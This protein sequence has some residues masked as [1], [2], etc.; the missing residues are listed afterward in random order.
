[1]RTPLRSF[2]L[3]LLTAL[4]TLSL[5]LSSCAGGAAPEMPVIEEPAAEEAVAPEPTTVE[6]IIPE[7]TKVMDGETLGSLESLSPDKSTFTFSQVTPALEALADGDVIAGGVTPHTPD[8]FLRKVT[9]VSV[10]GDRVVVQT[11][12]AT[13]EEA[14]ERGRI[15]GGQTLTPQDV[16]AASQ[17]A[18][19]RLKSMPRGTDVGVFEIEVNH[20]LSDEDGDPQT[21]SD[22]VR[23]VG[24]ISF[25]PSYTFELDIDHATIRRLTFVYTTTETVELEIQS[26]VEIVEVH[27]RQKLASYEFLPLEIPVGILPVLI[28]PVLT[29]EAG[30]DGSVS[31]GMSTS[32]S[33]S[34][35]RAADLRYD[36]GN[37]SLEPCV[38]RDFEYTPPSVSVTSRAQVYAGPKLELLIYGVVGPTCA[39]HGYLAFDAD[40]GRTPWWELYAGLRGEV[41][42]EVEV[43][44]RVIARYSATLFDEKW[45]LAQAETPPELPPPASG[46]G[47]IAFVSNRD[48]GLEIYVM[49]ADGSGLMRVTDD[50]ISKEDPDWSP[51]GTRIAFTGKHEGNLDVYVVS[52]DGSGL[53]RLTHDEAVD[54]DPD[55]SPDGARIAFES[56]RD[57]DWEI[58]VMNAD[59]SGVTRLTDN[60]VDDTRPAW[61]PDGG[62]IAFTREGEIMIMDADGSNAMQLTDNPGFDCCPA[63]SPD[64][65][66]LSFRSRLNGSWHEDEIFV[67]DTDGSGL[68]RLTDNTDSDDVSAWSAD[69]TRIVFD[70]NRDGNC[71]IYVM[72]A[73]GSDQRN[74]SN[75]PSVDIDPDWGR[76][77]SGE[78]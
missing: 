69:G 61:S 19:V 51:D 64:G 28:T 14:I 43:L 70:T 27:E 17:G 35:T 16:R 12:Q 68:T 56:S 11:V 48:G 58:Y 18:G 57:G 23:A 67:M 77:P 42:V 6:P 32:A 73:D 66:R 26:Q 9:A 76:C 44:S 8:G 7:T 52:A 4:L 5:S 46:G 30:V 60:A 39:V 10:D 71:E 22:Q 38:K 55:W 24:T 47:R 13:L 74:L 21:T 1:M 31:V 34:M 78:T 53:V 54:R 29:V 63:W 15:E 62:R 41:G 33:H 49:N 25:A 2:G 20:V 59:G 36:A 65:S 40:A 37:W 45:P 72:N 75:D 50:M 3:S